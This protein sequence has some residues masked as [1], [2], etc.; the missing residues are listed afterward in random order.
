MKRQLTSKKMTLAIVLTGSLMLAGLGAAFAHQTN[1]MHGNGFQNSGG[2][3]QLDEKTIEKQTKFNNETAELRKKMFSNRAEMKAIMSSANPD[4]KEAGRLAGELFD[5]KEQLR[6]KAKE[7]G[8]DSYGFGHMGSGGGMMG[9]RFGGNS[10]NHPCEQ[11]GPSG[12]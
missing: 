4:S 1:S 11:R 10:N 2:Q 3:Y 5:I 6:Q 7:L 12:R 9:G 8:L